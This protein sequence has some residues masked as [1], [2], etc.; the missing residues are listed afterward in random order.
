MILTA[1]LMMLALAPYPM[2]TNRSEVRAIEAIVLTNP[3]Q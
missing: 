2:P 1:S 3:R